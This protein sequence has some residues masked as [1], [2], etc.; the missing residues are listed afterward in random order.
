MAV[1]SLGNL[2]TTVAGLSIGQGVL[3]GTHNL[4]FVKKMSRAP[5]N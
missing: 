2:F 1:V 3:T 4:I 5:N